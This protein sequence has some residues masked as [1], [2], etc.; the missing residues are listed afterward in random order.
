MSTNGEARHAPRSNVAAL[1]LSALGIVFG[2]IGTSP[3]YTLRVCMSGEHGATPTTDNVFGVLS[4]I[5]WSLTMVIGIK[6]LSFIMKAHN[7]GEG[8]ICAL[9]AL[10]P[11]RRRSKPSSTHIG[12][13]AALVLIGAALLYGDGVITPAISVLSAVEGLEI[14]TSKLE[15]AIVPI[16]CVIL[17]GLFAL[18]SRGTTS[19]GRLFGPVMLLWFVTLAVL[20]VRQIMAHPAILG[21]LSPHHAIAFFSRSGFGGLA[22]LGGVVLAVTGGEA[23]YADMGHF[24]ARPIRLAWWLVAM[25]ALVVNYFGQGALMLNAPKAIANPFYGLVAPGA[26]TYGLVILAT[27]ATIIASQALISGAFSLTHQAVQLG[28]FPRVTIRHTSR[29]AEGQIYS[30]QIN[31]ALMIACVVLVIAFQKSSHLASAYGIA[32]TGTMSITSVV[33]YVVARET[34]GWS[35]AKAL[36]LLALFLS[37]DLTFFGANLVKVV[38]G[39][40]VPIVIGA[41]VFFVMVT[42]KQGRALLVHHATAKSPPVESFIARYAASVTR[43]PGLGV[44]MASHFDHVPPS[45]VYHATRM[46]VLP[47]HVLLFT[48]VT[49]REP[50]VEPS[51]RVEATTLGGGFYRVVGHAGY[52]ERPRVPTMIRDAMAR[53]G[54][55]VAPQEI[56]Y[57]LTHET[58]VATSAGRMGAFRETVFAYL[59]RNAEPA[60]RFFGI[61]PD[62]VVELGMQYDL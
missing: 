44:F 57:Y 47:E 26:Q 53:L 16:T 39:G 19:V 9:L 61:P 34:W 38:D 54:L 1:T 62:R 51:A 58:L 23:L 37:F 4:L 50:N 11:E 15:P 59:L 36:P 33:Y 17:V 27:L 2:D 22:V 28:Y 42:W 5:F 25:P 7:R 40:Y 55:E 12:F 10:V 24:G 52:I 46:H 8:G 56:T 3:L 41:I 35:R 30:P 6:Y 43:V 29:A 49:E 14:A 45:M 60:T 48:L 21:A 18:Q 13:V 31:A 32:V 20:G